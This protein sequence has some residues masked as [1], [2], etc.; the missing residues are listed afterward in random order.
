MTAGGR[1]SFLN[2]E[3]PISVMLSDVT[4]FLRMELRGAT[5][6]GIDR[7]IHERVLPGTVIPGLYTQVTRFGL[8]G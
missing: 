1:C 3:G 2:D 7:D 8:S 6:A 5:K 4:P